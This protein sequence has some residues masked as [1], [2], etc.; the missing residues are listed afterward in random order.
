MCVFYGRRVVRGCGWI[1]GGKRTGRCCGK[2]RRKKGRKTLTSLKKR[3]CILKRI[4]RQRP[5]GRGEVTEVKL[6]GFPLFSSQ[7]RVGAP[8]VSLALVGF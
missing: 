3:K 7:S 5:L 2:E 4:H 6:R 1:Y 8:L